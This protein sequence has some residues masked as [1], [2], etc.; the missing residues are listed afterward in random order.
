[1]RESVREALLEHTTPSDNLGRP[2]PLYQVPLCGT[3]L[4]GGHHHATCQ[5][6]DV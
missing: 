2:D 6:W 1:M 5:A 4:Q 3:R